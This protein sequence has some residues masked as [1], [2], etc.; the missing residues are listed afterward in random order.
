LAHSRTKKIDSSSTGSSN[1]R[2]TL[3]GA[4]PEDA[5]V[6]ADL[7]AQAYIDGGHLPPQSPYVETLRNIAPRLHET[8]VVTNGEDVIAAIAALPHGH[9]MAEATEPGEWEFRYLAVRKD[10]WG[11][12]LGS[13]LVAAV[14][15]QAR[16]E[17]A[18]RMVL[19]VVDD[20]PRAIRLYERRGYTHQ[21]SRDVSFESS[22]LPG[23][24]IN[25]LLYAKAL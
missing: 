21:P 16:H 2:F 4:E 11:L 12:G 13:R 20:N 15:S 9:P 25:L 19:R 6:I 3:R 17:Q 1:E 10:Q 24:M 14:E 22:T 7:T 5:S 18:E 8:L 23:R